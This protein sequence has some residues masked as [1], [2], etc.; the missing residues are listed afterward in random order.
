MRIEEY[1]TDVEDASELEELLCEQLDEYLQDLEK[2]DG[3]TRRVDEDD[4]I[5]D[6]DKVKFMWTHKAMNLI[7]SEITNLSIIAY[8]YYPEGDIEIKS[9]YCQEY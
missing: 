6:P 3:M 9:I 8:K 2:E 4:I 1:E 7:E 5:D